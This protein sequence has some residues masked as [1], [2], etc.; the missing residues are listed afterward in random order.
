MSSNNSANTVS[1]IDVISTPYL[2][3]MEQTV[4]PILSGI[5]LIV[6]IIVGS[7]VNG[8]VLRALLKNTCLI[9]S[10]KVFLLQVIFCDF[11][12]YVFI[13]IPTVISAFRGDW[14][15]SNPFCHLTGIFTTAN[16][17]AMF[18]LITAMCF[19]RTVKLW[20]STAYERLFSKNRKAVVFSVVL[21]MVVITVGCLPFVGWG[22]LKYI[23]YKYRCTLSYENTT[24][25]NLLFAFVIVI[26]SIFVSVCL[27]LVLRKKREVL[28]SL[29]TVSQKVE[30]I[31]TKMTIRKQMTDSFKPTNRQTTNASIDAHPSRT[32]TPSQ[33]K[34]EVNIEYQQTDKHRIRLSQQRSDLGQNVLMEL[35]DVDEE[36]G[37]NVP[38]RSENYGSSTTRSE[39]QMEHEI[40][41]RETTGDQEQLN[42]VKVAFNVY[43][44]SS[45]QHE[46]TLAISYILMFYSVLGMWLPLMILTYAYAYSWF[47][48]W[49]GLLSICVVLSDVSFCIKPIVYLSHNKILQNV[50]LETV[51]ESIRERANRAKR[52]LQRALQKVDSAVFVKGTA[53][54]TKLINPDRGRV[55]P[56]SINPDKGFVTRTGDT[57]L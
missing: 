16:V 6:V 35:K 14:I 48:V 47:S 27:V 41:T 56:I 55:T 18:V 46:I 29:R 21:W 1:A 2:L 32:A 54:T 19:E 31:N 23:S 7:V 15:L 33:I 30:E 22:E 24:N 17:I 25:M 26:P 37:G 43:D 39:H 5:V 44:K 10:K 20:N 9:L 45:E 34:T 36:K 3:W 4:L 11:S 57:K 12:A 28:A 42:K 40:I 53:D 38:S 52:V 51:P 13:H 8:L 49:D 50:A